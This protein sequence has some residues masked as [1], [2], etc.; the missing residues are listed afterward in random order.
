M[1]YFCGAGVLAFFLWMKWE[2][3]H[4]PQDPNDIDQDYTE[5]K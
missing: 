3:D 4:A 5:L 2:V 1:M